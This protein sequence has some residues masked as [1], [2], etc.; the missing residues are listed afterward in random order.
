MLP[1]SGVCCHPQDICLLQRGK[2]TFEEVCHS[3][4]DGHLFAGYQLLESVL[5]TGTI[6]CS[7]VKLVVQRHCHCSFHKF[8][9]EL[10]SGLPFCAWKKLLTFVFI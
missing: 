10:F 3:T 9:E 2:E 7:T 4:N 8:S 1:L 5:S 6:C